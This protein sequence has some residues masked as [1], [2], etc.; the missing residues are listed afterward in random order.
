M[1]FRRNIWKVIIFILLVLAFVPDI[2]AHQE[3]LF[4]D[5]RF[6]LST[7]QTWTF[8][9][10]YFFTLKS[11]DKSGEKG[12][13]QLKLNN[14]VV[15]SG[16][17]SNNEVFYYNISTNGSKETVI[18]SLKV[19]GIYSGEDTDIV[20]FSNVY[21]YFQ[22]GLAEPTPIHTQTPDNSNNT[23]GTPAHTDSGVKNIPGFHA[24]TIV[25]II[26]IY[27]ILLHRT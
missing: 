6:Y 24:I 10:D 7:G 22:P 25:I 9:Q 11:V 13:I 2:R 23:Q 19:S 21:Q 26:C 20:T 14:T 5:T 12:W 4:N 8:Y 16:I 18:F 27:G 3:A 1:K 17:L 15:K